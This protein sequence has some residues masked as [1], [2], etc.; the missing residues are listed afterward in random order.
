MTWLLAKET[1]LIPL[2][3]RASMRPPGV[4]QEGLG[5]LGV[6]RRHRVSIFTKPKSAR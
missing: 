5:A 3:L 6:G 1:I 4:E 2:A